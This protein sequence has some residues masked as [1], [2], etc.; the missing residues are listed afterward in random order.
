M[1]VSWKK[2]AGSLLS[3]ELDERVQSLLTESKIVRN[4]LDTNRKNKFEKKEEEEGWEQMK[5]GID[6]LIKSKLSDN[7]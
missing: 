1:E 4:D 5:K 6:L 3:E 2:A 7:L